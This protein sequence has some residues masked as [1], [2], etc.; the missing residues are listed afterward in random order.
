[1]PEK[2]FNQ[3]SGVQSTRKLVEIHHKLPNLLHSQGA[4]KRYD[5]SFQ[6]KDSAIKEV[7]ELLDLKTNNM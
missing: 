1:M 4:E 6:K 7:N 3:L 2:Y 5:E